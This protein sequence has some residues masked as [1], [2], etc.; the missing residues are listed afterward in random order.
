MPPLVVTTMFPVFVTLLVESM[1]PV[2]L[3]FRALIPTW[4]FTL[5]VPTLRFL[6]VT[7]ARVTFAG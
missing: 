2:L 7:Q 4:M 1:P 3:E 5:P 6:V